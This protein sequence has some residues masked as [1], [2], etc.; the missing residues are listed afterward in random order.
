MLHL[1]A[2]NKHFKEYD[3]SNGDGIGRVEK[4]ELVRETV[5]LTLE[6]VLASIPSI[7]HIIKKV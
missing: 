5:I 6:E 7:P 4:K 2:S 1:G 3:D